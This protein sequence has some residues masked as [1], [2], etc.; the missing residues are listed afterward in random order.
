VIR[1]AI[2]LE[3]GEN[4]VLVRGTVEREGGP[5]EHPELVAAFAEK[6]DDHDDSRFP[7]AN[8]EPDD[9][10]YRLRPTWAMLSD[11]TQPAPSP[12]P[13]RYG[14]AYRDRIWEPEKPDV[15]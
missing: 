14:R 3:D 10:F 13:G 2:N 1:V 6:Y 8:P 15:L 9:R 7:S 11:D 12:R 4:V 5:A